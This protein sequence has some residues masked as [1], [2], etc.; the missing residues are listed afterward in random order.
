MPKGYY[1]PLK[2]LCSKGFSKCTEHN[3]LALFFITKPKPFTS[4]AFRQHTIFKVLPGKGFPINTPS[5]FILCNHFHQRP[6]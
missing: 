2:P 5:V 4:K 6:E 3:L 1:N